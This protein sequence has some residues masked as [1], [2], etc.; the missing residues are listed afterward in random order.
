MKYFSHVKDSNSGTGSRCLDLL[1]LWP[2]F[3]PKSKF[4]TCLLSK[5]R[6]FIFAEIK[7]ITSKVHRQILEP[8]HCF[9]FSIFLF[10]TIVSNLLEQISSDFR[11][12]SF[13]Y[14][15]FYYVAD[16][17]LSKA[18]KKYGSNRAQVSYSIMGFKGRNS[19]NKKDWMGS[20]LLRQDGSMSRNQKCLVNV[21]W[22]RLVQEL[23]FDWLHAHT[24]TTS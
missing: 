2:W 17:Y 9:F 16:I 20:I 24:Y 11:V 21:I 12:L 8:Y 18:H 14:L 7:V 23:K 19:K 10:L 3:L 5:L 22:Q 1:I 4:A 6:N 15:S 13:Y